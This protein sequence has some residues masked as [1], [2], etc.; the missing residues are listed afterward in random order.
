[1]NDRE[2]KELLSRGST[3]RVDFDPALKNEITTSS[4]NAMVREIK[5]HISRKRRVSVVVVK[6][7]D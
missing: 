5:G 3:S 6:H 7:Q 2:I 4:L 1:M